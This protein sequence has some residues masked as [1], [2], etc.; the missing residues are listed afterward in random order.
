MGI[1]I[2]DSLAV[3]A[4]LAAFGLGTWAL[5]VFLSL[6]LPTRTKGCEKV[7]AES[8][9][10]AVAVG[11][12]TIFTVGFLGVVLATS[13]EPL[14]KL[15]GTL[16]YL[17]VLTQAAIGA[18][19]LAQVAAQR[20]RETDPQCTSYKSMVRGTAFIV[21]ASFLPLLGWF[22][23]APIALAA[24]VGSGVI[25]MLTRKRLQHEPVTP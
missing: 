21:L 14:L 20:V 1:T 12:V 15:L 19:G 9:G 22:V 17:W 23:F 2:G 24:S 7:I 18:T 4:T 6:V 16:V 5:V 13:P 11:F 25:A 10:K 8:P 3:V